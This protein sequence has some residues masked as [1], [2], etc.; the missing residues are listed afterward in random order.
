MLDTTIQIGQSEAT[1]V[2]PKTKKRKGPQYDTPLPTQNRF[3]ILEVDSD[4][5]TT[6]TKKVRLDDDHGNNKVSKG[7]KHFTILI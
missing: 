2:V 3:N 1:S 7:L 4:E 5:D 6:D